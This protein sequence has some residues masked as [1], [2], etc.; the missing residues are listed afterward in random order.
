MN[1]IRGFV[2]I[3]KVDLGYF[4]RTKWLI[5]T[6]I[7]LNLSDMF[8]VGLVYTN[9][10]TINYFV[11]FAPGVVVAG[12]FTASLDVGR[13]VH[14]GLTEGVIQ[15]YLSLPV[16]VEVLALS[17]LV[18][19]GLAGVIYGGTLLF[20]ALLV[21]H[22]SASIVLV[23]VLLIMLVVSMGLGG[24]AAVMN[25]VSGGGDRYWQFAEGIQSLFLGMSTVFYPLS[26]LSNFFPPIIVRVAQLNPLTQTVEMMRESLSYVYANYSLV[27]LIGS[28][29][30][31][32]LVGFFCYRYIFLSV[33]KIGKI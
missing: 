31:L 26:T 9:I 7:A 21:L 1:Q 19:A 20:F 11:F 5:L 24:I 33:K 25:L 30:F 16:S 27:D 23:E 10:M 4:F 2:N 28:S 12:L 29:V 13:R 18:S 6:L 22:Y 3:V 17:H 32:L 8:V 15:Y 14:L